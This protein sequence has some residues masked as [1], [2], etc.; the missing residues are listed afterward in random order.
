MQCQN[1]LHQLI[2]AVTTYADVQQAYP[3]SGIVDT[4]LPHYDPRSGT[5]FSWITL[6]L[7]Q[8]EQTGLHRQ[9]DFRQ[10]VLAQSSDPQA[11]KLPA[12]L[13][14]SDSSRNLYYQDPTLTNGKRLAKGNYVAWASPFHTE[15]QSRFRRR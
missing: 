5:M 9:F 8:L 15:L 14:P 6:I 7:P 11:V 4:T 3:A 10:S 1:N 2:L 12:L 13:C